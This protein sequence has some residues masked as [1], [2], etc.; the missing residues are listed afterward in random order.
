MITELPVTEINEPETTV[1]Q[2]QSDAGIKYG[3]GIGDVCPQC[4]Q[5]VMVKLGGCTECSKQCGFKGSCDMK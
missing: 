4:K 2:E 5:G 3:S 1:D